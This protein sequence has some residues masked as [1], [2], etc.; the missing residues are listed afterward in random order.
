MNTE[1]QRTIPV[2]FIVYS[3]GYYMCATNWS[4]SYSA[5]VLEFNSEIEAI[6]AANAR[7]KDNINIYAFNQVGERIQ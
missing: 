2:K 5:G 7:T 1:T 6:S 3:D 4:K